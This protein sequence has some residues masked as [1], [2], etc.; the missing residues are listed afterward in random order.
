MNDQQNTLDITECVKALFALDQTVFRMITC[1][2]PKTHLASS[3]PTP[4]F[5]I[6]ARFLLS[7]HSK[8][9]VIR[10]HVVNTA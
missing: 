1:G 3:K 2:S 5:A 10:S 9:T 8:R 4:C 7:S 6:F